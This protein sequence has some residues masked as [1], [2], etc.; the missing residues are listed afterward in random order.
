MRLP[1]TVA[2]SLAE[3]ATLKPD[4]KRIPGG[5]RQPVKIVVVDRSR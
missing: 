4:R 3:A 2:A 5:V 1:G